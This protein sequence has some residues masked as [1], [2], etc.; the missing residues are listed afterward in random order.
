MRV[1]SKDYILLDE[2][3]LLTSNILTQGDKVR[4]Y[5]IISNMATER[6]SIQSHQDHPDQMRYDY[7]YYELLKPYIKGDVLDIGSGEGLFVD[8]YKDN[9]TSV[10]MLDKFDNGRNEIWHIGEKIEGKY[11]TIVSTEFIEHITENELDN[12][13]TNIK[14]LLKENGK[15]IGS[16]PN[17]DNP[18]GN[19]F[20]LREYNIPQ[21]KEKLQ[22]Y[23][24]D[25][26]IREF[27][28]SGQI[29]IC[30]NPK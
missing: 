25:V 14:D 10:K 22:N 6:S 17:V 18:S 2:Y 23:F 8:F 26:E 9:T 4:I 7:S 1:W 29:F 11:D 3:R 20:H 30:Q 12:L 27:L 19:P 16:T 13:L 15:F 21:L 28:V 24:N 5:V